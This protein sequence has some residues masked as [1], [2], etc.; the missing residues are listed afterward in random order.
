MHSICARVRVSASVLWL[1]HNPLTEPRQSGSIEAS[2]QP[3]VL[4]ARR[5]A[6]QIKKPK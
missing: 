4:N 5:F 1:H 2:F 6:T 3:V